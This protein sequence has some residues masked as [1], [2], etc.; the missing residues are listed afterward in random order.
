MY[1]TTDHGLPTTDYRLPGKV[2]KRLVGVG[3]LDGVFAFGHGFAF[4]AVGGHQFVGEADEHWPACFAAAGG[5][6]PADGEALL[7]CAIHLHRHLIRRPA[8][9]LGT[10]LDR[11]L[12]VFDRLRENVDRGDVR[13]ALLDLVHGAV[14]D[15]L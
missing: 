10:H 12:D 2:R 8:D 7:A 5:E 15:A 14:E 3:H 6:Q 11:R 1:L 13:H 9:A 4:T